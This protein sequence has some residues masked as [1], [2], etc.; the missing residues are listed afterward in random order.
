MSRGRLIRSRRRESGGEEHSIT[1]NPRVPESS[2]APS[3]DSLP[4][5]T[6][7]SVSQINL[8]GIMSQQQEAAE[9]Y[10]RQL[11]DT[12][13]HQQQQLVRLLQEQREAQEPSE[14]SLHELLRTTVAAL[15][16]V[17]Q[18]SGTGGPAVTRQGSRVVTPLPSPV[19]S[20]VPVPTVQEVQH[21]GRSQ[22]VPE[23]NDSDTLK[24]MEK[25]LCVFSQTIEDNRDRLELGR[26]RERVEAMNSE[27]IIAEHR[28]N[29]DIEKGTFKT[30]EQLH[31]GEMN[32][33]YMGNSGP[34]V[35]KIIGDVS[36]KISTSLETANNNR[37]RYGQIYIYDVQTQLALRENDAR[38]ASLLEIIG[39]LI[40]DINPYAANFKTT[41]ER[42][43]KGESLVRLNFI[44]LKED[45]RRRYNAPTCGELAAL[46]V[47]DDGAVSEN[48]EVQVFPK[49][50]RAVGYVPRYSHHVD[51]MTFPLL[52]PSGDLGWSYNMK[53]VGTNKE[54]SPVQ[55]YGHRLALR[56]GEA[57]NQLL[58]SGR[59]T[60]H[61]VIHAYLTIESQRLLFLRNNQKQ[62]RVECYKGM[63]DHI[64]NSEANTSDRTRLGNQM[65]LPSS[66][67]G[68]M[69]HMQQQYQDAMAITRKVGRPDLFITMTCNP[70]WPEICTVLKDFP[71]GTTVNDIPTIACRIFNM[72]LQQALKKIES[73]SVFGKIEGYVYTV[74]FQKRGLPHAHILFIL[75]NNDK[76]LT[77]EAIDSF[78]SAEI[79]DK[80]I[81]QQ[82]Y[83]SVT[84]HMLHGPH[85]SKIP[86][87]NSVTKSCSKKFPKDL[88][89]NTDIS[90]GGFPKYRRRKNT[91]INYYRNRVEGRNI[92][93]DNSMVVPHN[94][95]LLAKYDCHMN[96]E[97][98]TSIMAIKYVFKYIHKGHDR[99]RVQITDSNSESDGQPIINE[100]QD[101]VDSRY[102]GPMEAAWRIL[103]LPMHGRSHAVT[104][105][106]VHLPGQQYATFE[107]GREVEAATNEKKWRTHLITWF[108]LNSID[109]MAR[110]T[111]YAN[112]P[113]YYSFQEPTKTWKKRKYACQVVSRMTNVSPR[114]SERFH[115]KLILGHATNA[116][117]FIDLRTVNGK[118]W[119]TFREAAVDMGLT[120]TNDE[121]FKIFDEAVS[122][123]MPKRLRH[124]FVWYLIGEMPSNAIDL[125]NTYKKA[126]SEDF[127]DQ[128][129]NRALCAIEHLFRA[130]ARSCA[131]FYLPIPEIIFENEA[132]EIIV[133]NIET[134]AKKGNELV[135][136]LNNDQKI[137]YT[138]IF[139]NIM[140]NE[141]IAAIL[142]PYGTTAH[143]TFGL[144]LTLQKEGTIF[145]NATMKKK[146]Q[147]IDVFIWDECSMIP[148]I[149]KSTSN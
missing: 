42:F 83:Q 16:S 97:Y 118:E 53:H 36:Y 70:K 12:A 38:R 4:V 71:T 57:Q 93:V 25:E 43:V 5:P 139:D 77:P 48:I 65:I 128:H 68:S 106:P 41:Y 82:L 124:F 22:D 129:E 66:F 147:S 40:I 123:L 110:N 140:D 81:H 94:P 13:T 120:A 27:S 135:K 108:E 126:L 74:E 116:R 39:R 14:T 105:L 62:L 121:A 80:R 104:R 115:L 49:Q 107:G 34:Y 96:V 10:Q 131:D 109:E 89:E 7:V 98:C 37:P 72:R 59:L 44:A 67:S 91:D 88:V 6:M 141:S 95:Y 75:N 111:T 84:S 142:L 46:I 146:I 73:G 20:A 137:I 24:S 78:I 15:Q 117:S 23:S 69:R 90:G 28:Y 11:L 79:P 127:V 144:P 35:M 149:A 29:G 26:N 33:T 102:V 60:Q 143:K 76:L 134:F 103:E 45:D 86:C 9:R 130:E 99:A 114:D 85:T 113:D 63:T 125:W 64:S 58:R 1:E 145:T 17:H 50:D 138:Q 112:T 3:V 132:E 133:E 119:N 47:S 92:Q 32:V 87:W 61:Y 100:I 136:Q 21:P 101:Y 8:L 122:L 19:P 52:F 18:M 55:Y 54:I 31:M 51:P 148:K 30:V 56:R 2:C